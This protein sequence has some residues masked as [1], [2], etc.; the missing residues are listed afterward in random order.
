M[1]LVIVE[2]PA[3]SK[4]I[5]QYLGPNFKVSASYG[6]VRDLP[7]KELGIDTKNNFEPTYVIPAK[8][9]K[10]ISELKGL[11][12]KADKLYLAT[13]L[14][15]EGEA[16]AWHI[17]EAL[18]PKK[19]VLRITFNEITKTAIL[20]AI[21]HPRQ[22][23]KD[24]VDAQQAR[25]ILD[26]LV[27][28]KL[29][30]FLWKKVYSGLSA[31]RVQSVAVRLVVERER[32]IQNFK[33]RTYYTIEGTFSRIEEK[34]EQFKANLVKV[35]GKSF[36][37]LD[38]KEKSDELVVELKKANYKISDIKQE[39][40]TKSPQAPF[41]TSTLQQEASRKLR[42]SAKKTMTV[43]QMLYEG[44]P[45]ERG[46]HTALIT[47]MRTDSVAI[48]K[49]AQEEA[50]VVIK[51]IYGEK[52]IP[53]SPRVYKTKA[54]RAQEAHESIRPVSF[55][56]EPSEIKKYLSDDQYRLYKLVY[57]RALASQMAD[58]VL[59]VMTV[60]V[61]SVDLK[62]VYVFQAK[63]SSVIFPGYL[64][65]YEEGVDEP[66]EEEIG[67]LPKMKVSEKVKI[68]KIDGV[69]HTTQPPA[70]YTEA[71]LVKELEKKEIGRPS[72]YAPIM[73]TIVDRGYVKKEESRFA[74]QEVAFIVTDLLVEHFPGVI[75]YKF[76]AE[77]EDELDLVAEGKQ[78]W[79]K[80]I[81][82]FYFPFEKDLKEKTKS[83]EK[84]T[85]TAQETDEKCPECGKNLFIKLGRFGKFYACGGYPQCKYTKPYLDDEMSKKQETQVEKSIEEKCPNCGSDLVLKEGRFGIF[86][87]CSKYPECKFTK[88]IVVPSGV[89]CP[90]CGKDLVK[91]RTKKGRTFWGCSSYPKCKTA[92]WDEPTNEKCPS[93]GSMMIKKNDELKCSQCGGDGEPKNEKQ[94]KKS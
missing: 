33:S 72:T 32:E 83:V 24:L 90:N 77:M 2:S 43:A 27:G 84:S 23:N 10:T 20:S 21:K 60:D 50:L 17:V 29:S 86:A 58:A 52:Y 64:K 42:F 81:A 31:G 57:E 87:A 70:R 55:K 45:I 94:K 91:K 59:N 56:N 51:D 6:H 14:D 67:I 41:T 3:K 85:A 80:A 47:Y 39:K 49:S 93:C 82:D 92:F 1:N 62:K 76:T 26:R 69:E 61:S 16:I 11:I 79:Q 75:D 12:A 46:K 22:L 40:K 13:D 36:R 34:K 8:S 4:T 9:K 28:Y 38:S 63:G 18:K 19:D 89:K 54:K 15:R 44:L 37:E 71:T 7:E 5:E 53:S 88:T 35:D 74:P 48:S 73:S 66:L 65:I 30:P 68:E 25:R 78:E